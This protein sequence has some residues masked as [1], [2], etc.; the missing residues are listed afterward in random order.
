MHLERWQ[1]RS[2]KCLT[3]LF[4]AYDAQ[5]AE[6]QSEP[7]SRDTLLGAAVE[8]IFR[9]RI[10]DLRVVIEQITSQRR[11]LRKLF[12][13]GED[14]NMYKLQEGQE[15]ILLE[16]LC[17]AVKLRVLDIAKSDIYNSC[18]I[19]FRWRISD[20]RVVI[21]QITSQRR[22]LRKLLHCWERL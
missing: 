12:Q 9:W 18:S 10:S 20:L 19:I 1:Q 2:V 17:A 15:T 5:Q 11:P 8:I 4:Q 3:E 6:Q 16:V 22:P 7:M 14:K 21:E 13:V